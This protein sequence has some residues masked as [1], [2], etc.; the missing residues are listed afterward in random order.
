[1]ERFAAV[2]TSLSRDVDVV[3]IRHGEGA[4]AAPAGCTEAR[5][6]SLRD[7]CGWIAGARLFLGNNSGPMHVANALGCPGVAVT[8]SSA[9][10]WDPYWNRG[11]WTVLR[12]P[13]LACA[14]CETL[15]R[16]PE[17]CANTE[18]PMA[19]LSYWTAAKVEEA[20]RARLEGETPP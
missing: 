20:C 12:H 9:L 18:T 15:T 6:T 14:P 2:A 13:D 19:C 4:P 17:A 1:V 11:A 8:G 5:V 10:G 3:W 7:L 16:K